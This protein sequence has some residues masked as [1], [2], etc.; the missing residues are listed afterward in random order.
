MKKQ[1]K[2]SKPQS[3][4]ELPTKERVTGLI[5]ADIFHISPAFRAAKRLWEVGVR[6][7]DFAAMRKKD[8]MVIPKALGGKILGHLRRFDDGRFMEGTDGTYQG[9]I[10]WKPHPRRTKKAKRIKKK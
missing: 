10:L 1:M 9:P 4:H 7:D 3:V 8:Y 5:L 6:A 2:E